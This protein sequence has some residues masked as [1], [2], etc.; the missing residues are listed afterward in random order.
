MPLTAGAATA[1]NRQL[2]TTA[3]AL[4][5]PAPSDHLCGFVCECGCD[6]TVELTLAAYDQQDGAR[7]EGH[8]P[9]EYQAL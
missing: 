5:T 8:K 6:E 2:R 4:G 1:F 7:R 3:E 9:D